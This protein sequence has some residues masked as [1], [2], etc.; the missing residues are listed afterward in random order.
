MK[1]LV[2]ATKKKRQVVDITDQ[3]NKFLAENK[4][5]NGVVNLVLTHTTA[6]LATADLDPGTD[7]DMLDVLDKLIPKIRFR[8]PHN[9]SH[10]PDHI[11][12]SLIVATLSLIVDKGQLVL[13]SWQRII[14]LEFDGPRTREIVIQW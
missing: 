11:L 6:A 13:G 5:K 7:Q 2:F 1:K 10:T 8:H 3:L 4:I 12:S 9:P 14:L